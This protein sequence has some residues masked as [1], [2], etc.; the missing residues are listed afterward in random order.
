MGMEGTHG[1]ITGWRGEGELEGPHGQGLWGG[2]VR[3]SWRGSHGQGRRT[4]AKCVHPLQARGLE[5]R[6]H[7]G[8]RRGE[9][10]RRQPGPE[11][12]STPSLHQQGLSSSHPLGHTFY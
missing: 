11:K 4:G 7:R 6:D 1:Q 2:G 12:S 9:S 3:G 8:M 10:Q 5:L